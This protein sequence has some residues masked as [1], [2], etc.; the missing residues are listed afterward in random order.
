MTVK[1]NTRKAKER[2]TTKTELMRQAKYGMFVT[3]S[4]SGP[5]RSKLNF[6]VMERKLSFDGIEIPDKK[7]LFREDNS[8]KP[9][10]LATVSS[11]YPV[12]KHSDI[13][14]KIEEGMSF[15]N[16]D[17]QTILSK[18]GSLMTRLYTIKDY[19]VEVRPG[20]EISPMIR[21]VNSYD[22]S[23]AVGFYI[24]AVRL[25]CT[26]GMIA[27][28]QFMS[29]SYK[30][31]GSKFNLN[32]FSHNAHELI[33]GFRSY[34]LNWRN[35]T[36]ETVTEDRV[37]LLLNYIPKRV[38]KMIANRLDNNFDYTKWGFYNACTEAITHDYTPTR[39]INADTK[40]IDL[41]ASI[42]KMFATKF[43]WESSI[44]DIVADLKK[45]NKL[46]VTEDDEVM[47]VEFAVN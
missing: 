40:K 2:T 43:Y 32:E 31:F 42:T 20:D 6:D 35:W 26:N 28:R 24:D 9:V 11:S 41:G 18:D 7:A 37:E 46:K 33:K 4:W 19:S 8:G 44:D 5:D 36:N 25:V 38:S 21:I 45:K 23:Q 13:V 14:Q 10:Y 16:T 39:A 1:I 22:G 12:I 30:H 27:T 3:D 17:I 47:N 15:N 29:M 34:S